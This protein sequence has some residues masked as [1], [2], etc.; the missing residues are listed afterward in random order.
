MAD[1]LRRFDTVL[2]GGAGLDPEPAPER[3]EGAGLR[4]V[5]TY[6]MS[7]TCGGCVYDG[8]PLDGVEVRD[9]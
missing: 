6:G 2:I 5:T 8:R 3:A 9:G 4:V 1:P 7:E